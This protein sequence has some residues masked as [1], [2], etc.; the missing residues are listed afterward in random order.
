GEIP[1]KDL[2]LKIQT[3]GV[4]FLNDV[5]NY[6]IVCEE[7]AIPGAPQKKNSLMMTSN[8]VSMAALYNNIVIE[9]VDAC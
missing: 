3:D 2:G 1:L 8:A 4:G 6:L 9:E 7:G 5:V